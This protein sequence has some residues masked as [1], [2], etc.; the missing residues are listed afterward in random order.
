MITAN[1]ISI[2]SVKYRVISATSS[3]VGHL[4][5]GLIHVYR[6][7]RPFH[8]EVFGYEWSLAASRREVLVVIPFGLVCLAVALL[9]QYALISKP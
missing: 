1:V 8:F 6:L 9:N 7:W 4:S 5:I 3:G 2:V